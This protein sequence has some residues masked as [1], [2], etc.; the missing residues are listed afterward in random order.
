MVVSQA[1]QMDENILFFLKDILLRAW[2]NEIE[3]GPTLGEE[4]QPR[5]LAGAGDG[6][7]G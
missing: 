7:Q 3:L 2:S 5:P 4:L 1:A 6:G